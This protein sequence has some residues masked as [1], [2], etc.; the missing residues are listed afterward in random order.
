M[1][2]NY[3][4]V[5]C[6]NMWRNKLHAAINIVG[7][8]VG[9]TASLLI[10]LFVNDEESYDR[11]WP[12][13]QQLYVV[14]STLRM[15]EDAPWIM[16]T[17]PAQ[18]IALLRK[19]IPSGVLIARSIEEPHALRHGEIEANEHVTWADPNFFSV[20]RPGRIAGDLDTA[21]ERPDA[22]VLS[23]RVAH[24]YFG[25]ASP[26]GQLMEID[27]QHTLRVTA[28]VRDIPGNSFLKADVF[29]SGRAT[30]AGLGALDAS[31]AAD[32]VKRAS[33]IGGDM[34]AYLK[35]SAG[36]SAARV[37]AALRAAGDEFLATLKANNIALSVAL[38][39]VA[40]IHLSPLT[41]GGMETRGDPALL[42][43]LMFI[44]A[45]IIAI[46][47]VNFVNLMTARAGRRATE[48]G[49]R[50]TQGATARDLFVQFICESLLY[51]LVAMLIALMAVELLLP[52]CNGFLQR[53]IA[54]DYG[55][56]LA[57]CLAVAVLAGL[58]AGSYPALVLARWKPASVL[59]GGPLQAGAGGAART[60][61]VVL[62]F[63]I[64]ICLSVATIVVYRQVSF[65]LNDGL[66][67]DKDQVL[68][69]MTSCK[70]SFAE[71]VVKL[72]GVRAAAC[73]GSAPLGIGISKSSALAPDGTQIDVRSE[74]VA[75][76]LLELYGLKPVA[77]RFFSARR[78]G[79]TLA[80]AGGNVFIGPVIL[81]ETAVRGLHFRSAQSAVGQILRRAQGPQ[82]ARTEP[83]EIIGVVPDMP[84]DG[85]RS[86][87]E[88]T[89]FHTDTDYFRVLSVKLAG[90][91]VP[92]TLRSIDALWKSR[93]EPRPITRLFVAQILQDRYLRELRQ[94]QMFAAFAGVALFIACLGLFGLAAHTAERRTKEIGVRKAMGATRGEIVRLL[95][96]QLTRP[97]LVAN[98][99]AWPV[100]FYLMSRWLQ[101]FAYHI[102]LALWMFVA[103]GA[104]A[105]AIAWLTVWS[106]ACQV[107]R[108]HPVSALRYE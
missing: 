56:D 51:A 90:R 97:V 74:A 11:F 59:R 104:L 32:A 100:G 84:V 20:L 92:E 96:W 107:A 102:E 38:L 72:P 85:M 106:H 95:L 60:L 23:E 6:R 99:I 52:A 50:K 62:Q 12:Q 43:A 101:G 69:I 14:S 41:V 54:P 10:A 5:A 58:A 98:L 89:V 68:A 65:A 31:Y 39:P 16:D 78:T 18:V 61:L 66:R 55:R 17:V 70:G 67:F 108:Q 42:A 1:L 21:L 86:P 28:V 82:A 87:V 94:G 30:F 26:L 83:S 64:L 9:F 3:L 76:G 29:A 105:L 75:P 48:I 19:R 34:Q 71:E 27:R 25:D 77:G 73:S 79:E 15:A 88:A 80:R 4:T 22:L 47:G 8:A 2:R 49:V 40:D 103:A 33:S 7:L 93:G 36:V 37:S 91:Q 57:F 24:K 46:A 44:G 63:A 35:V 81:N 53:D 13:H 45:G